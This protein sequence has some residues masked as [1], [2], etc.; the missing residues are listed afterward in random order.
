MTS[1]DVFS[2]DTGIEGRAANAFA[3]VALA[4]ELAIE[5]GITPWKE[6]D[7]LDAAALAFGL[8]REHRG[9]GRTETRQILQAVG[10]FIARHGDA[11]FSPLHPI[12]ED[13]EIIVRDRAGWWKSG[14]DGER[15][16]LFLSAAL[17]EAAPGFD[18]R[19]ILDALEEGRWI[20]ER[21]EG[22]RSKKTKVQGRRSGLGL[23]AIAPQDEPEGGAL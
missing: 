12:R 7:A 14:N 5:W 9:K 18:L 21:D 10:D 11:R 20:V 2:A 1:L 17:C 3:L 23:Y 13:A 19:R 4:G 15:V 8:W 6:G 22:K 16:Y